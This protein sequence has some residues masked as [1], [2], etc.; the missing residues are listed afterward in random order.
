LPGT[1]TPQFDWNDSAFDDRHP[2]PVAP[3][4]QPETAA[5]LI[6]FLADHPRRNAWVGV[7]SAYTVLGNRLA[8]AL[9][10]RYLA[11]TGVAGQLADGG[12]RF[13]SNVFVPK[14]DDEDQG[15]HGMFDDRA[16]PHDP[17]SAASM[18]LWRVRDAAVSALRGTR[19]R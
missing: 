1:N 7:S 12:P 4:F 13:G 15:A 16:H 11:K 2:Q 5:R 9:L 8:P 19:R 17:L 10:D 14:D 3:I 6:R 18:A